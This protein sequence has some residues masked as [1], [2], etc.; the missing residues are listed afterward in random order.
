MRNETLFRKLVEV[1]LSPDVTDNL[2]AKME[3]L[4]SETPKVTD[5]QFL[6]TITDS[7]WVWNSE[8]KLMLNTLKVLY[9]VLFKD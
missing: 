4:Y 2:C 6:K 5:Y 8:F 9:P 3:K 7:V 1:Y